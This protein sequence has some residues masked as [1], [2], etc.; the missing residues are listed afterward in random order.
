MSDKATA[1]RVDSRGLTSRIEG[2]DLT[3][4]K[5]LTDLKDKMTPKEYAKL[6]KTIETENINDR[7]VNDKLPKLLIFGEGKKAEFVGVDY[8]P[9]KTP[10]AP[11]QAAPAKTATE[12]PQGKPVDDGNYSNTATGRE[13]LWNS[14]FPGSK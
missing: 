6:L 2:H 13:K 7:Q 10:K 12:K 8:A 1:D 4:N 5:E 9:M 14:F 3:A 11:E